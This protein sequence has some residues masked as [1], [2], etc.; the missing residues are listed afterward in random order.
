MDASVAR[1]LKK[2]LDVVSE[3]AKDEEGFISAV[4]MSTPTGIVIVGGPGAPRHITARRLADAS[5]AI[6]SAP[7]VMIGDINTAVYHHRAA[8]LLIP[9]GAIIN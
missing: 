3:T 8:D 6:R 1:L 4:V 7:Y 2:Y 5:D 9:P